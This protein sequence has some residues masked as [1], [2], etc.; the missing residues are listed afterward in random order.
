MLLPH[1]IRKD[2]YLCR[3]FGGG[4]EA[5]MIDY[6][7]IGGLVVLVAGIVVYLRRA[8]KQ[9]KGCIGCPSSGQCTGS[10]DKERE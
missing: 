1:N 8:K 2:H 10:C 6:I 7:I 4:R 5:Y 9:G 3:R